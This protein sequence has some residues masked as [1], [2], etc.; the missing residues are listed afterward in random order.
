MEGERRVVAGVRLSLA[1]PGP[2][3]L[4]MRGNLVESH[5]IAPPHTP[6]RFDSSNTDFLSLLLYI[7]VRRARRW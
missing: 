1:I 6:V 3:A 4:L 2:G 5:D 7:F